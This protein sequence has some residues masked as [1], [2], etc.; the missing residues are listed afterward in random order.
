MNSQ[1]S[2]FVN[3]FLLDYNGPR[4]AE[5]NSYCYSFSLFYFDSNSHQF[6]SGSSCWETTQ[7]AIEK[8]KVVVAFTG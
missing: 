7:R 4:R 3:I 8:G 2:S 1:Q 6:F 5:T